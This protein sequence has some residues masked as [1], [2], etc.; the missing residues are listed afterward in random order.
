MR[1]VVARCLAVAISGAFGCATASGYVG[2][3]AY[4]DAESYV[5]Y[6]LN[7]DDTCRFVGVAKN[8]AGLGGYCRYERQNQTITIVEVWGGG[9]TQRWKLPAPYIMTYDASTDTLMLSQDD[10]SIRLTR[11]VRLLGD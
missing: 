10:R 9:S 6:E 7:R 3:W 11:T 2:T 8:Q 1:S 4:E 5:G